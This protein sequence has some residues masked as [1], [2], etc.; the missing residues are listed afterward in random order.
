MNTAHCVKISQWSQTISLRIIDEKQSYAAS[1]I[2]IR[3]SSNPWYKNMVF[4]NVP[5][6][7]TLNIVSNFK[8]PNPPFKIVSR[9]N[10]YMIFFLT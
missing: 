1:G 6:S 5:L 2:Y 8:F 10:I 7:E 9:A 4:T 3:W